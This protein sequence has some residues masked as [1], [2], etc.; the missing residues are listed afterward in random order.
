MAALVERLREELSNDWLEQAVR[1]GC[2]YV[3]LEELK[4]EQQEAV[5]TLL[6]GEIVFVCYT[7]FT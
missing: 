7:H 4:P 3:G 2:K 6:R 5:E 1:N